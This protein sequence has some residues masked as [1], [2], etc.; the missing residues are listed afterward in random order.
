MASGTTPNPTNESDKSTKTNENELTLTQS[1]VVLTPFI[2]YIAGAVG[3]GSSLLNQQSQNAQY[4][5]RNAEIRAQNR[6][7][8]QTYNYNVQKTRR[9][10]DQRLQV[11]E[12]QKKQ[13][14]QQIKSNSEELGRAWTQEQVR[15][16]DIFDR[17]KSQNLDLYTQLLET[18]GIAAARGQTGRRAG[19][20]DRANAAA[21]G[22][23]QSKIESNLERQTRNTQF[24]ME[25]ARR[26]TLR[27]NQDA[28]AQ[29]SVAPMA[30]LLP[31]PPVNR[32]QIGYNPAMG[33]FSSL[34]S[35]VQTGL[36]FGT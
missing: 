2:P 16:N 18:Q 28:Y 25:N 21:F 26:A 31:P 4:D 14:S 3:F 6:A 24:N 33:V 15:L 19:S 35:G 7:A 23:A 13:Y 1:M 12:Q 36:T 5:A 34:L 10:W 9:Q 22:R 11:W 32:R 17:A 27:A 30:P 8:L 20:R 29:V